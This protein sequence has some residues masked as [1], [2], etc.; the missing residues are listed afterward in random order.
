ME[1]NFFNYVSEN[2]FMYGVSAQ[3]VG[4]I[5]SLFIVPKIRKLALAKS[6]TDSPSERKSHTTE[7]PVLGGVAIYLACALTIY[8]FT[9][10]FQN[11]LS[12]NNFN[13]IGPATLVLLFVGVVDDIL[14]LKSTLKLLIELIIY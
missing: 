4:C 2:I 12:L 8:L 13:V 9:F 1:I 7:I 6:L 3:L 5:L 11:K 14:E 10:I